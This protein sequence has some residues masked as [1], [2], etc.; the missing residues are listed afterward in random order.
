MRSS[1]IVAMAMSLILCAYL[2]RSRCGERLALILQAR[3]SGLHALTPRLDLGAPHLNLGSPAD[4]HIAQQLA[5]A[6][7]APS[8]ISVACSSNV[9]YGPSWSY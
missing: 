5:S 4:A 9:F 2:P 1:A 3:A 7:I 6:R 8:L